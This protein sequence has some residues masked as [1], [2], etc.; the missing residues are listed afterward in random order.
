M[1]RLWLFTILMIIMVGCGGSAAPGGGGQCDRGLCTKIEVAEPILWGEAVTVTIT[2]SYDKDVNVPIG[3]SL[4][5]DRGVVAE[6]PQQVEK[7]QVWKGERG[8][9]WKADVSTNQPFTLVRKIHFPLR[10][11]RFEIMASANTLEGLRV[12]D[13]ARI[14]LTRK[15]G[16]VYHAETPMPT[17]S[18]SGTGRY[19]SYDEAGRVVEVDCTP[20]PCLTIRVTEPVRWGEAVQVSLQVEG[21]KAKAFPNLG[22]TFSSPD[23]SVQITPEKGAFREQMMWPAGNGVWWVADLPTNEAQSYALL[24]SFPSKEGT[25]QLHAEAYESDKGKV[26]L[27]MVE[28][29]LN[30]KGSKVFAPSL[31][32]PVPTVTPWPTKLPISTHPPPAR[33]PAPTPTIPTFISPL[34]TATLPLCL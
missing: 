12:S 4:Y 25:Y 10:E 17:S 29:H 20:G 13:S 1:K 22:L 2:V 8:I 3:V 6:E 16:Q 33:S 31:G 14:H 9:D 32:T 5:Y 27:D 15:E 21:R 7:W 18:Q 28:I 11:G 30:Q 34:P 23:P 19:T 24:V 26:S